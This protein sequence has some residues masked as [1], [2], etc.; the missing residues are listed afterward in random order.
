MEYTP[1]EWH[2]GDVITEEKL[3][4]MV[5]G[6]TEGVSEV[7]IVE[8]TSTDSVYTA[9]KTIK[10]IYEAKFVA[11]KIVT[12]EDFFAYTSIVLYQ[13]DQA[14]GYSITVIAGE[15]TLTLYADSENDYP[16]SEVQS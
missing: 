10:E 5:N 15:D 4:S 11:Y 7:L 12:T 3:N 1:V 8:L 16:T 13:K 9:N 6:I 2:T 14:G